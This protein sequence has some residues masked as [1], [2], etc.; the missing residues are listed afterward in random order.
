M[1]EPFKATQRKASNLQFGSFVD[2][3]HEWSL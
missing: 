2:P 1:E 3:I